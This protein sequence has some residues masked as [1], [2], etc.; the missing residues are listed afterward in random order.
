VI[1]DKNFDCHKRPP[2]EAYRSINKQFCERQTGAQSQRSPS[3][4]GVALEL[5]KGWRATS[6]LSGIAS[7]R[8]LIDGRIANEAGSHVPQR[9]HATAK[10]PPGADLP[11]AGKPFGF[12]A[13]QES[14][15]EHSPH[16]GLAL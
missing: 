5:Q 15:L 14:R 13:R 7:L 8:A 10:L 16:A 11:L 2:F 9:I 1:L 3:S 12:P 6:P 4:S